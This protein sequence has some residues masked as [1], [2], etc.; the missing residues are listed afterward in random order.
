[1]IYDKKAFEKKLIDNDISRKELAK[2]IGITPTTLY[3]KLDKVDSDF[4]ISEAEAI[5]KTLRLNADELLDIFF[6]QKLSFEERY[7]LKRGDRSG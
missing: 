4:K 2:C 1:M 6:N 5:S 7:D 3:A